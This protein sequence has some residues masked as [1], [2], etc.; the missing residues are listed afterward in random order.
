M[1]HSIY[2]YNFVGKDVD[3]V[4]CWHPVATARGSVP[5]F[6]GRLREL[7]LTNFIDE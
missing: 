6:C 4:E 5:S 7:A 2:D 1:L 3:E